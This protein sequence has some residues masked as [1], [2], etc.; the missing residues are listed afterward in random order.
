MDRIDTALANLQQVIRLGRTMAGEGNIPRGHLDRW[1]HRVG[2][3]LQRL[4]GSWAL[5]A[6]WEAIPDRDPEM[7]DPR[8]RDG[9]VGVWGVNKRLSWLQKKISELAAGILGTPYHFC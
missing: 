4:P 3:A 1:V 6:E 2:M 7:D 8:I 5:R 9:F